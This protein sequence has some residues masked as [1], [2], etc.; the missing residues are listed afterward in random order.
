MSIDTWMI[1]YKARV[2]YLN[3]TRRSIGKS[4]DPYIDILEKAG[5]PIR[6]GWRLST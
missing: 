5:I 4:L 3:Q 6:A 1:Y 2:I